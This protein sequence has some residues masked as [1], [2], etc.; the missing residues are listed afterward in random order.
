MPQFLEPRTR[1]EAG[2]VP[3]PAGRVMIVDD[4]YSVRR[5]LHITLY[6]Q[7]FE[8]SEAST[9]EEALALARAIRCDA[10][11]LDVNLPARDGVDICQELRQSFPRI[12]ILD[13]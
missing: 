13:R 4:D 9:G 3:S 5:A 6:D 1:V 7:G 8:V 11:L 2:G 12:A 10:V